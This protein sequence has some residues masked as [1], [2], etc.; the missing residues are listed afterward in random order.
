L[1][2]LSL[3]LFDIL[4]NSVKAGATRLR[5]ELW[6]VGSCLHIRIVDNGPGFPNEMLERVADPYCTTRT[7][8]PVGLGL[9]FLRESAEAT[10]GSLRVANNLEGGA[11]V[12]VFFDMSHIDARPLGD[13]IGTVVGFFVGW[14]HVELEIVLGQGADTEIVF[15][16]AAIRSELEGV[17][18]SHPQVQKFVKNML[19]EAM[20]KL[21]ADINDVLF[22]SE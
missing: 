10:G 14:P 1:K 19:D 18:P 8:R 12:E 13:I 7:E 15:D 20:S 4:E 21:V 17:D 2:D 22:K 11:C 6:L 5:L 3:H 9:A 16:S